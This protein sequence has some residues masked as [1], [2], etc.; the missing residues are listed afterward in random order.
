MRVYSASHSRQ[1]SE[2]ARLVVEDPTAVLEVTACM[3]LNR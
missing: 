2:I 1:L 3:K